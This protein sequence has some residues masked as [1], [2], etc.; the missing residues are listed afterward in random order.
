MLFRHPP[1]ISSIALLT[2][3]PCNC[4]PVFN[5]LGEVVGIAFQSY[6]GSDAENIGYVIPTPVINHF[7]DDYQRCGR[8]SS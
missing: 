8:G 5:E 1:Y 7:L 4:S 2:L 6:A 3:L